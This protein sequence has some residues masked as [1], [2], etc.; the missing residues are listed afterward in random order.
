MSP[1]RVIAAAL[2]LLGAPLGAQQHPAI[3]T[4]QLEYTVGMRVDNGVPTV[5]RGTGK[6]TVVAAGDSL[7]GTL[8]TDPVPD[9]PPRPP[10]RLA[11]TARGS[12]PAVFEQRSVATLNLNGE[13]QQATAVSTWR[14][15]IHGDSIEGTVER[16]IE[17]A[18]VPLPPQPA[19]PVKGTRARG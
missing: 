3:G 7:I 19:Q 1:S 17:G 13:E 15:H 5:I 12:A 6:L 11:G 2:T 14:L 16:R 8:E 9:L 4:W 10:A 18:S